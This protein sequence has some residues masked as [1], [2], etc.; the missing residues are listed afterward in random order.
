MEIK[1][2]KINLQT[3]LKVFG[4]WETQRNMMGLVDFQSVCSVMCDHLG[5]AV[6]W[7]TK[8]TQYPHAISGA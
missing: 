3:V 2:A 8:L 4:H 1:G 7:G 6:K 5:H